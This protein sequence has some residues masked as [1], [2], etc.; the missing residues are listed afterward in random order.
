MGKNEQESSSQD[1]YFGTT[2]HIFK[3]K[4]EVFLS[5]SFK[6]LP[7]KLFVLPGS[8]INTMGGLFQAPVQVQ[9][10]YILIVSTC[11]S[12]IT[13]VSTIAHGNISQTHGNQQVMQTCVL[14][15]PE[16][17]DFQAI[18]SYQVRSVCYSSE[19]LHLKH[20]T[21]VWR[22][23]AHSVH[24]WLPRI[25]SI[26]FQ[27]EWGR[28]DELPGLWLWDQ[29]A[30]HCTACL[31]QPSTPRKSEIWLVCTC[32]CFP[33]SFTDKASNVGLKA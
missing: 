7:V 32:Q 3:V 26:F 29:S 13:V 2:P 20:S 33:L 24:C 16:S 17:A 22:M 12:H 19:L 8:Q 30:S 14:H 1:G 18:E 31:A 28:R 25:V 21:W 10:C 4:G 9:S 11:E 6:A 5:R 23:G 15:E 27:L